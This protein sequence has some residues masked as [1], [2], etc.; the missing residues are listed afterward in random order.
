M[1]PPTN[2][3]TQFPVGIHSL[4]LCIFCLLE[5]PRVTCNYKQTLPVCVCVKCSS[6]TLKRMIVSLKQFP[7]VLGTWIFFHFSDRSSLRNHR[8]HMSRPPP[9]AVTSGLGSRCHM[10]LL[11]YSITPCLRP[12]SPKS[13]RCHMLFGFLKSRKWN[14]ILCWIF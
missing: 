4:A 11:W 12:P 6:Y 5:K 7:W 9:G 2:C 14:R 10:Q 13:S 1:I 8:A 3:P